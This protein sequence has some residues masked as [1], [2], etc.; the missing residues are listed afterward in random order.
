[1]APKDPT[2]APSSGRPVWWPAAA[3][4]VLALVAVVEV[5]P[6]VTSE[7]G[8]LVLVLALGATVPLA[9]V[10]SYLWPTLGV[11]AA[12]QAMTLALGRRP[13]VAGLVVLVV[14][15]AYAAWRQTGRWRT[16]T[17]ERE[18]DRHQTAEL[19]VA[20]ATRAERARIAH[21]LHDVVAHHVSL[22]A[23]E[24]ETAR[25]TIPGMPAAGAERLGSIAETARTA[26]TEMRRLLGVL[27]ADDTETGTLRV[28]TR[29]PQ[30]GLRQLVD[31]VDTTRSAGTSTRLVVRGPLVRLDPAVELV[32][33]RV[34]QEALTNARRHAPG[35]AVDVELDCGRP[36]GLRVR[37]RDDGPGP[38]V[39][40][41][42]GNGLLGMRERVD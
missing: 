42:G 20:H 12:A 28:P 9:F 26:L 5:L 34:V 31:L 36:D 41:V 29:E 10:G 32:V 18:H 30:P 27:R 22:I 2:R 8:V 25:L 15:L 14:L 35:A 19:L 21:E 16:R 13:P 40:T 17:A 23:V 3:A 37:V 7:Q 39:G 6:E 11:C 4:A 24:A 38:R 33:Y 1:M